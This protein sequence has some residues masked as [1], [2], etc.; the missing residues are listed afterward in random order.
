MAGLSGSTIVSGGGPF[1]IRASA[2]KKALFIDKQIKDLKNGP[3][4]FGN[5][6]LTRDRI[7]QLKNQRDNIY[8]KYRFSENED[9]NQIIQDRNLRVQEL[10]ANWKQGAIRGVGTGIAA[11]VIAG[12]S[13]EG[14]VQDKI[15]TGASTA[16][17]T[18]LFS[19]IPGVGAILGPILG[20]VLGG[21]FGKEINKLL[22]ADEVARKERV[23]DAKKQL[24]AIKG[25]STSVTGL[26]DIRKKGESNLWDADDWK[27]ANEYVESIN[28]AAKASEA[29]SK[30]IGKTTIDLANLT[31][32]DLANIE[33]AR[34]RFEA[35]QTYIAGEQDR[36][37]LM[38]EISENQKKLNDKDISVREQARAAIVSATASLEEY[39]DALQ[40][41]Y[42]EEAF[43][44]S[45]VSSMKTVD[46]ANA[47]IDRIIAEL[48]REWSAK[49]GSNVFTEGER[50]LLL[51]GVASCLLSVNNLDLRVF[52]TT[53]QKTCM[54]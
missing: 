41:S 31:E 20:P 7:V 11:G 12:M 18:G 3:A 30:A 36:Y 4:A 2:A 38:K 33:A 29:F 23:E 47:T 9:L 16:I 35:E 54:R 46:I 45:G 21:F 10:K 17:T 1:G 48:A 39:S 24:E 37:N 53:E 19:A 44:S 32:V 5:E 43:Y 49:G 6:D 50:L 26:I 22:K 51:L 8:K 25:I 42:L 15:V 27:Q 14:D 34:I 13:A 52:L 28:K 40:K